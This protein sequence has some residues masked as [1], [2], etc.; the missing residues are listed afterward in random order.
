MKTHPVVTLRPKA[1]GLLH[2]ATEEDRTKLAFDVEIRR[3]SVKGYTAVA[4]CDAGKFFPRDT[5]EE[6]DRV[7]TE[8]EED[9][10]G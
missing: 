7:W 9:I 10:D 3:E 5:Y 6:V 2:S 8:G 4:E 1:V